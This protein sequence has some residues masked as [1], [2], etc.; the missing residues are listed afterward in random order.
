V[1]EDHE[2]LGSRGDVEVD[3]VREAGQRHVQRDG[4]RSAGVGVLASVA[5]VAA[6]PPELP[7]A[8]SPA[9]SAERASERASFLVK[10]AIP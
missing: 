2:A 6:T 8:M 4:E 7:Q 10:R 5:S 9:A 3:E 1:K